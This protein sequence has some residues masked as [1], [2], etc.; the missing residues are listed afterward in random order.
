MGKENLA[1]LLPPSGS[2]LP[3][4]DKHEQCTVDFCE[5]SQRDFTGVSQRHE[6]DDEEAEQ[7]PATVT[8]GVLVRKLSFEAAEEVFCMAFFVEC[9]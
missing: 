5:Y 4:H 2:R 3:H 8:G 7:D 9:C 6:R 1:A